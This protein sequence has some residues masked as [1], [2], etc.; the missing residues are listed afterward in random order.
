MNKQ[1]RV[2]ELLIYLVLLI[3][4]IIFLLNGFRNKDV[5]IFPNPT[6]APQ[7]TDKWLIPE[8]YKTHDYEFR[9]D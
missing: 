2:V 1:K 5:D 9:E 3:V 7:V 8:E 6:P 4:G